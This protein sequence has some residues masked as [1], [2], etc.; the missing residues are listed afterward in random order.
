MQSTAQLEKRR[1]PSERFSAGGVDEAAAYVSRP[2][3]PLR[4][5][6]PRLVHA[7]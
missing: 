7:G 2:S 6:P 5:P 4:A 3:Q 1:G